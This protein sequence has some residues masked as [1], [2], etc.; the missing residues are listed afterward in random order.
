MVLFSKFLHNLSQW[1][2]S[3]NKLFPCPC[4]HKNSQKNLH[5]VLKS[6]IY[7]KFATPQ[8]TQVFVQVER[9][10]Y[11]SYFTFPQFRPLSWFKWHDFLCHGIHE[12]TKE[13]FIRFLG[14]KK[15][16]QFF[17]SFADVAG[18]NVKYKQVFACLQYKNSFYDNFLYMLEF[19][20]YAFHLIVFFRIFHI[21]TDSKMFVF[22]VF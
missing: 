6:T 21:E 17:F 4:P 15:H 3:S 14:K 9:L 7:L 2:E 11:I 22:D 20:F 5:V 10:F 1:V 8:A 13:K 19:Y 18:K 12:H 16:F